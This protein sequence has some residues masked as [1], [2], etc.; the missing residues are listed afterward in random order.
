M[1]TSANSPARRRR[2]CPRGR[3]RPPIAVPGDRCADR[4]AEDA[5][6]TS[7][8]GHYTDQH[9]DVVGTR[10]VIA[11]ARGAAQAGARGACK[12]PQRASGRSVEP[13]DRNPVFQ[14]MRVSLADAEANVASLRA[15]ARRRYESQ[16]CA[17][18]GVGA[19][20]AAGRGRV[21][22]A[23]SRLRRPEEDLRATCS[24]GA[25]PRRWAW[26]CRT[27]AARSSASSIR[28]AWRRSRCRRRASRCSASRFAAGAGA[29]AC[30]R[31]SSRASSCRRS[32]TRAR[33]ARSRSARSSAW[34]R[35]CRAKRS[36]GRA[37]ATR[38]LFAGGLSG[39]I[40]SFAAVFAFALLVGRVA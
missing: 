31:A 35:C 13:A 36:R 3:R 9:P 19:T 1:R 37:G 8:C 34:C 12:R 20:G 28:R 27:P 32:T 25:K 33:C 38:L 15:Q 24:R 18:Q 40:A 14:Q 10:R 5:S 16:Y 26:T 21:R 22:A 7:C 17:A 23:Q 29:P 4:R 11:A 39:L 6:S 30:W 2:C